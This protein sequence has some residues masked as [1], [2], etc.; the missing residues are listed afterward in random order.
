MKLLRLVP[1]IALFACGAAVTPSG[2]RAPPGDPMPRVGPRA[3]RVGVVTQAVDSLE[4]RISW[5]QPT[6]GGLP[7]TGFDWEADL[8]DDPNP[9]ENGADLVGSVPGNVAVATFWTPYTCGA[10]LWVHARVR[11]TGDWDEGTATDWSAVAS[12]TYD[13]A[14]PNPMPAPPEVTVD[15]VQSAG[16]GGITGL[17]S[18]AWFPSEQ[19]FDPSPWTM[20]V[21]D[22]AILC[23]YATDDGAAI[24]RRWP[25]SCPDAGVVTEG[26]VAVMPDSIM[27]VRCTGNADLVNASDGFDLLCTDLT[28]GSVNVLRWQYDPAA[29]EEPSPLVPVPLSVGPA[30]LGSP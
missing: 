1:P 25:A 15:T 14:C 17:Q 20:A 18:G 5:N 9:F 28:D 7:P 2:L 13:E 11:A 4:I 22:T 21:G 24:V 26:P 27:R 10:P 8:D 12:F 6:A 23:W 30:G 3:V 29:Q 19:R 16:G